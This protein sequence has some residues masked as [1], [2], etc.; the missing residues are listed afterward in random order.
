LFYAAGG[1]FFPI[2]R[3][4]SHFFSAREIL[5]PLSSAFY[6]E[7]IDFFSHNGSDKTHSVALAYT[8]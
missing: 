2:S 1:D 4:I 7:I 3:K 6:V 8:E 5:S